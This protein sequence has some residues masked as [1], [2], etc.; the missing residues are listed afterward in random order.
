MFDCLYPSLFFL[1]TTTT[2][3]MPTFDEKQKKYY[4]TRAEVLQKFRDELK[5]K[6]HCRIEF[7]AGNHNQL[8][9]LNCVR[10]QN[11]NEE[12]TKKGF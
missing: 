3:T 12:L 9:R 1:A 11:L 8:T 4:S 7:W 5:E 10:K 6:C 2:T